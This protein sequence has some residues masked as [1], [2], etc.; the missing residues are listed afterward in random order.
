MTVAARNAGTPWRK[1]SGPKRSSQGAYRGFAAESCKASS[2]SAPRAE[3]M[4]VFRG[5]VPNLP[6]QADSVSA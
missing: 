1:R 4:S 5:E 3:R 6:S 2:D